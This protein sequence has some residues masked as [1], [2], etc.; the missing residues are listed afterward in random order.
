MSLDRSPITDPFRKTRM[1]EIGGRWSALRDEHQRKERAMWIGSVVQEFG[2][3]EIGILRDMGFLSIDDE[4]R[5]RQIT[6]NVAN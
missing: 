2:F 5:L 1:K 4:D 3:F 6:K